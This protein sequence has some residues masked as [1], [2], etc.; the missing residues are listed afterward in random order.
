MAIPGE[1]AL[2]ILPPPDVRMAV[3]VWRLRYDAHVHTIPPHITIAYPF[4]IKAEEWPDLKPDIRA[5]LAD[6]PSFSVE[7]LATGV[8]ESPANVLWLRPDHRGV[9]TAIHA[10]LAQRFPSAVPPATFEFIPHM[11]LGF[12]ETAEALQQARET[13]EREL[14]PMRFDVGEI[15]YLLQDVDGGWCQSD[16][17]AIG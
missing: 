1:S 10:A 14:R 7:I 6:F 15:S 16:T 5:C 8:F 9:I 12:F 3:D 2:V 11:T 4:V 17:V 13:V